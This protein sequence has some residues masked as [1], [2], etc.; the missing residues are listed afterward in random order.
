MLEQM[1]HIQLEK[2]QKVIDVKG[3]YVSPGFARSSFTY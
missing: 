3:K 2:K 1:Q